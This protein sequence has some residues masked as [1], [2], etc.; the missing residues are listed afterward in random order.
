MIVAITGGTGFIGRHL[1]AKHLALG[2]EVRYLTRKMQN[3]GLDGATAFVG[4]LNDS[5]SLKPF[6]QDVDVLYHCAAELQDSVQMHATNVLGTKNLLELAQ[7]KVK[8]WVQLSSTGVYG[9]QLRGNVQENTPLNPINDYEKS[10]AAADQLLCETAAQGLIKAVILRPSNVYGV[11][12]VNQSLFQL[13]KMVRRGWFFFI[14]QKGAIANYI[15]VDNVVDALVLCGTA[16]LPA[17][18]CPI[19]IVS[20]ST[21]L[22]EFIAIMA[23]ALS[24]A[25]PG[26]RLPEFLIRSITFFAD[27]LPGVSLRTSRVDA[28]TY[29]H[30][31]LTSKIESELGY[32][33]RIS[34]DKGISQLVSHAK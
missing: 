29:K 18:A 24:I 30:R 23:N 15:H 12:M 11:D 17:N 20:D 27:Y 7:G 25:C 32:R 16:D 21:T 3:T 28:L 5:A 6:I 14:G 4:D 13:I 9:N 33:H 31:Y 10:K 34:M 26:K 2:D 22:E 19:Y 8:R 1:I